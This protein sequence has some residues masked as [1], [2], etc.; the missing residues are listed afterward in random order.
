MERLNRRQFLK[1]TARNA[2]AVS[3][4]GIAGFHLPEITA[5]DDALESNP[6]ARIESWIQEY[7]AT[8]PRNSLRNSENEKA[9]ELLTPILN[10]WQSYKKHLSQYKVGT[11]GPKEADELLNKDKRAWR[12]L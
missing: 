6:A 2:A 5:A 3:L 1:T 11:W 7:T 12:R 8:S 4:A 10:N 9:W